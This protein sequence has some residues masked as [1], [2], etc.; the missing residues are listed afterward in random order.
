M[1]TDATP[2]YLL[3]ARRDLLASLDMLSTYRNGLR[4]A[5]MLSRASAL[6]QVAVCA[7]IVA[8]NGLAVTSQFLAGVVVGASAFSFFRDYV[9]LERQWGRARQA[10]KSTADNLREIEA[11]IE[12]RA[13]DVATNT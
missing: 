5:V 12:Q 9:P 3:S 10:V 8:G 2:D 6:V 1:S 11:M 4:P 7:H 13:N